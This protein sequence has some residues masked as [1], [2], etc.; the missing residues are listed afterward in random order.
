M[1]WISIY[2]TISRLSE[3]VCLNFRDLRYCIML[4]ALLVRLLLFFIQRNYDFVRM[5]YL[6]QFRSKRTDSGIRWDRVLRLESSFTSTC[7]E[8]SSEY[9]PLCRLASV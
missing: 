1:A 5:S 6:F 9:I 7:G 8:M 4:S 3:D 2:D